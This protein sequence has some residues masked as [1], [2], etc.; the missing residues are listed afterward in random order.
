MV[1]R[2]NSVTFH[3]PLHPSR[4][5]PRG[6]DLVHPT[7]AENSLAQYGSSLSR[8]TVPPPPR[9]LSETPSYTIRAP[10]VVPSTLQAVARSREGAAAEVDGYMAQRREAR[11]REARSIL[12]TY[13]PIPRTDPVGYSDHG[14]C[15]LCKLSRV[16][17]W[18]V[19]VAGVYL[20]LAWLRCRRW[21]CK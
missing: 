21:V 1:R 13:S 2:A 20:T 16:F 8:P 12:P 11:R 4:A 15:D 10:T 14:T 5:H 19:V 18:L 3:T 7:R 17:V 6:W 9:G